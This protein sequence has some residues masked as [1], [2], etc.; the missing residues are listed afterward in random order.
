MCVCDC[1]ESCTYTCL[2]SNGQGMAHLQPSSLTP[3]WALKLGPSLC[4]PGTQPTGYLKSIFP[5][6]WPPATRGVPHGR[7]NCCLLE[8]GVKWPFYA[9]TT[10][11]TSRVACTARFKGRTGT[12]YM[13]VQR[14]LH[15]A[16]NRGTPR[17]TPPRRFHRRCPL[18]GSRAHGAETSTFCSRVCV[19]DRTGTSWANSLPSLLPP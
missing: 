2:R 13:I 17:L 11:S 16:P 18:M 4:T 15:S 12:A 3:E 5:A 9:A 14:Q 8:P 19:C 10:R 1:D 7:G 6:C